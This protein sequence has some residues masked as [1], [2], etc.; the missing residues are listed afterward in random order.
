MTDDYPEPPVSP[1]MRL[2]GWAALA[3]VGTIAAG[4]AMGRARR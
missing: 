2:L 1:L 4:A 3:L